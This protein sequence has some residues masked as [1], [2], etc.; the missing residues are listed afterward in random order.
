V[1][2]EAIERRVEPAVAQRRETDDSHVDAYRWPSRNSQPNA[3]R[4]PAP[5]CR[6]L[7]ECC[8]LQLRFALLTVLD[9]NRQRLIEHKPAAT[10][11]SPDLR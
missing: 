8:I 7:I 9:L 11:D 6:R 2:P 1:P 10:R 4:V 3:C 5:V